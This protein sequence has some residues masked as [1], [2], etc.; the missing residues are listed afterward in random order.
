MAAEPE[1]GV[2]AALLEHYE[3]RHAGTARSA[4][5]DVWAA[6]QTD[7]LMRL[8]IERIAAAQS[9]HRTTFM[10]QLA[11]QPHHAT[12]DVGA[13]HAVDL[14]FVFDTFDSESRGDTWGEF[15]GVDEAG[16]ELGRTIRTC[17]GGVRRR[18]RPEHRGHGPVAGLRHGPPGDDDL[19]RDEC[20]RRRS[21][22]RRAR[23]VGR[24]LAPG[25][26]ARG[27]AD[28]TAGPDSFAG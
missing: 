9:A 11:W 2:A 22:R 1:P 13:F 17:V 16:R 24:A 12:R 25:L 10:Y 15:L 3:E 4:G 8:P 20:R 28:L 14:P 7:G 21:A 27:R 19:R 23:L 18:R 26:H 6:V 5:S